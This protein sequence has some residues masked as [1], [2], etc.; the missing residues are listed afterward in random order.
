M[1]RS[2][3]VPGQQIVISSSYMATPRGLSLAKQSQYEVQS[4]LLS[5][6]SG[7]GNQPDTSTSLPHVVPVNVRASQ[8]YI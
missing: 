1:S 5:L 7:G 6:M 3:P 2:L 4:P 8:V